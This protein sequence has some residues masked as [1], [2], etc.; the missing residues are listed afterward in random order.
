LQMVI[1]EALIR[2]IEHRIPLPA[3]NEER[4]SFLQKKNIVRN[5]CLSNINRAC[6]PMWKQDQKL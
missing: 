3:W 4:H 5:Y 2:K 6:K 1:L